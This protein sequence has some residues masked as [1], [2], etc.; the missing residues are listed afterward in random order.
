MQIFV[1]PTLY[2]PQK[3]VLTSQ[4]SSSW[5][6]KATLRAAAQACLSFDLMAF[7][8]CIQGLI[9]FSWTS[10]S[11]QGWPRTILPKFK[12]PVYRVTLNVLSS[13]CKKR[14]IQIEQVWSFLLNIDSQAENEDPEPSAMIWMCFA[15]TQKDGSPHK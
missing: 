11:E 2:M 3:L 7:Q 5:P 10:A 13:N 1:L 15:M 4:S 14:L 8:H 12:Y 6:C 9:W